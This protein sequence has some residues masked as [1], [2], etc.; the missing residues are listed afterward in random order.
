MIQNSNNLLKNGSRGAP[1]EF[2]VT[3]GV[4]WIVGHEAQDGQHQRNVLAATS[5]LE[6]TQMSQTPCLPVAR[7]WEQIPKIPWGSAPWSPSQMAPALAIMH[8]YYQETSHS[9]ISFS[10]R[11]A[12]WSLIL[13]SV[14]EV[15]VWEQSVNSTLVL[16]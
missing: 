14:S 9:G 1:E 16:K 3:H 10:D 6:S 4:P 11:E 12:S 13:C 7:L 2:W 8:V 15:T 5:G